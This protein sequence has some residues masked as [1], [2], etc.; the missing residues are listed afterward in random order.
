VPHGSFL[1]IPER[2]ERAR[3]SGPVDGGSGKKAVDMI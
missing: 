3:E 2:E 1:L